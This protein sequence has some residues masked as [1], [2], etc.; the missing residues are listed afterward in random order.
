MDLRDGR[1]VDLGTRLAGGWGTTHLLDLPTGD[2]RSFGDDASETCLFLMDGAAEIAL[3]GT[4]RPVAAGTGLT[5]VKG[6]RARLT[7]TTPAR[8]FVATLSA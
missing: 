1:V 7:A 3:A 5:L 2:S 6:T 8:L 4:T